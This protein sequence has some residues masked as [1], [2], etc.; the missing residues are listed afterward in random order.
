MKVYAI[1]GDELTPD[2][3]RVWSELQ[4][5]EPPIDNP[6]LHPDFT[7]AVAAVRRDVEVAVLEDGGDYLGFL[8]FQRELRSIG[9]PVA[10]RISELH[11]IVV[12]P[13][14][15]WSVDD[16]LRGCGLSM[17]HFDC[18]PVCQQQ[19]QPFHLCQ[20]ETPYIDLSRGYQAYEEERRRAGSYL[21]R[22]ALRKAR[23]IERE[24]GPLRF[25]LHT[26]DS[27]VF[28]AMC[29]WKSA[30][31]KVLGVPDYLAIPS[32]VPLLERLRFTQTDDFSGM[33][34]ALYVDDALIAVHF[35]IVGHGVLGWYF[36]TYNP[37]FG[38]YSPGLIFLAKLLEAAPTVGIKRIDLGQG[39]EPY[40]E[41]FQSGSF[42]VAEGLAGGSAAS[43][44][45]SQAWIR[46]RIWVADSPLQGAPLRVFR[47]LRN[48]LRTD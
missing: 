27:A 23:K 33:L 4:R 32:V 30:Q 45:F 38:K 24:V 17:W 34:S 16:V 13:Q 5:G 3:R 25:E 41:S 10:S 14:T 47:T 6:F 39:P 22:Q 42:A 28:A 35:G 26:T 31:Y 2:H 20:W 40:K 9:R 48:A 11:G 43:R 12:R 29:R 1:K 37:E 8:P 21:L 18:V 44:Q 7:S 19:F 36:P 15:P 46:T